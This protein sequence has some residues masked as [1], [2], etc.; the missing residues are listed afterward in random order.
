MTMATVQN[1]IDEALKYKGIKES[2][3]NSNKCQFN[4]EYYGKPVSGS[5]YPWCSSPCTT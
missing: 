4:T 1:I 2:P 5:A 3:P